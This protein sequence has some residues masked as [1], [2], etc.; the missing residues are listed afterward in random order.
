VMCSQTAAHKFVARNNGI[1]KIT[2]L[3]THKRHPVGRTIIVKPLVTRLIYHE[4]RTV[5]LLHTHK[6]AQ[7]RLRHNTV[8]CKKQKK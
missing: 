7:C 8:R 5:R 2:V 4:S 1:L 6:R 3:L